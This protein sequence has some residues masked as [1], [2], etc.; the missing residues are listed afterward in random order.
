MVSYEEI[1]SA[2]G[3][4][5]DS[6]EAALVRMYAGAGL[7]PPEFHWTYSPKAGFQ[8]L[9]ELLAET[10]PTGAETVAFMRS[11]KARKSCFCR[12][13]G[14][15][16]VDESVHKLKPK[17]DGLESPRRHVTD[18]HRLILE[19]LAADSTVAPLW[20]NSERRQPAPTQ[21]FHNPWSTAEQNNRDG[22]WGRPK[23]PNDWWLQLAASAG[24]WWT[25]RDF[26]VLSARP[27][28]VHYTDGLRIHNTSGPAIT[29]PDGWSINAVFG[30]LLSD[31]FFTDGPTLEEVVGQGNLEIRRVLIDLYG[32]ERFIADAGGELV[33]EDSAGELWIL[34]DPSSNP[35]RSMTVVRV[36]DATPAADGTHRVYW[37]HVPPGMRTARRAVAWTFGL[38]EHQYQPE[39]E[40]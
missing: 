19:A 11:G 23:E 4:D 7:D 22:E 26:A 32:H 20:H 27:Q 37:I 8:K 16:A 10:Y 1:T 36:V 34:G 40:T 29:Y 18:G 14:G 9:A 13:C 21:P 28:E 31:R 5:P 17:R 12:A 25:Y 38:E 35:G 39:E 3:T 6:A 24:W 15:L 2:G 33:A 30:Q